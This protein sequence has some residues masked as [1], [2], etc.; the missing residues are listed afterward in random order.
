MIKTFESKATAD[1][2]FACMG[3]LAVNPDWKIDVKEP[4]E[5][6]F[7]TQYGGYVKKWVVEVNGVGLDLAILRCI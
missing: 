2:F 3:K 5:T 1:T 7:P 4:R 6:I